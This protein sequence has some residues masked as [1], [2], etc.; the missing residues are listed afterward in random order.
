M[1]WRH[2]MS[3]SPIPS[4]TSSTPSLQIPSI[5]QANPFP[6]S[7]GARGN[8]LQSR[9]FAALQAFFQSPPNSLSHHCWATWSGVTLIEEG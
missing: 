4:S 2:G 3:F 6:R 9:A 8:G 7:T 5:T 1:S